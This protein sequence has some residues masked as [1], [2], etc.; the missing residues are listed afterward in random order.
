MKSDNTITRKQERKFFI[1]VIVLMIVSYYFA[2]FNLT[3][4]VN[5]AQRELYDCEQNKIDNVEG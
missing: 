5:D 4:K 3:D 1:S 2:V